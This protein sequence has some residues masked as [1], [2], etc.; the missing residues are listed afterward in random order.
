MMAYNLSLSRS[1]SLAGN[2]LSLEEFIFRQ[3]VLSTYRSLM[4][5][6]YKHH[7][8]SD[9]VLHAKQEFKQSAPTMELNQRRYLLQ[10]GIRQINAMATPLGWNLKL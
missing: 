10:D 1:K 7:E 2:A 6:I 5:V 8:K 9:L 4:R 3:K